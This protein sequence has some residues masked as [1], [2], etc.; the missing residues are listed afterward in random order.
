[1]SYGCTAL[2]LSGFCPPD[3]RSRARALSSCPLECREEKRQERPNPADSSSES[4]GDRNERAKTRRPRLQAPIAPNQ[5]RQTVRFPSPIPPNP[6]RTVAA[7]SSSWHLAKPSHMPFIVHARVLWRIRVPYS[8]ATCSERP[9][10][11]GVGVAPPVSLQEST[12]RRVQSWRSPPT[13]GY[14][15][16][17]TI[18]ERV[19]PAV[20]SAALRAR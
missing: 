16:Q 6:D 10:E 18:R 15:P 14:K 12:S 7:G 4:A 13:K 17:A 19:A 11:C 1:M 5:T 2:R 20:T 8:V 9:R 3:V